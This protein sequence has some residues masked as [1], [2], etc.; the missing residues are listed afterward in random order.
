[1]KVLWDPETMLKIAWPLAMLHLVAID[2]QKDET[3]DMYNAKGKKEEDLLVQTG[4]CQPGIV[5]LGC[6]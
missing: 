1:V 3:R 4:S 2:I 6:H 5:V